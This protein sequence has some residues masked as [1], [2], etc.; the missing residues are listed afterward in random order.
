MWNTIHKQYGHVNESNEVCL[1]VQFSVFMPVCI[2]ATLPPVP[3]SLSVYLFVCLPL[4]LS[5]SLL[6]CVDT[7]LNLPA[8]TSVGM[9]AL[10]SLPVHLYG[11]TPWSLPACLSAHLFVYMYWFP[12]LPV[13]LCVYMPW[14]PCLPACS[15]VAVH[16]YVYMPTSVCLRPVYTHTYTHPPTYLSTNLPTYLLFYLPTCLP[17]K[18]TNVSTY[19][20]TYLPTYLLTCLPSFSWVSLSIYLCLSL[21][22][23]MH[24][25]LC[26]HDLIPATCCLV[27]YPIYYLMLHA[28]F[29]LMLAVCYLPH[30][31]SSLLQ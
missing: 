30:P 1:S 26:L 31:V 3:L 27:F 29:W 17:Y 13:H 24:V 4:L 11:Y 7:C 18:P 5:V 12:C 19:L 10:V 2:H 16:L 14:S 20:P 6:A 9:H 21:Y 8:C 25:P 23:C 28:T 15:S 22:V